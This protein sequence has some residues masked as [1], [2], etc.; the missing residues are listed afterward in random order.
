MKYS[1]KSYTISE[2]LLGKHW[3]KSLV[4][5]VIIFRLFPTKECGR[6]QH[7]KPLNKEEIV[8]I[9]NS[10]ALKNRLLRAYEMMLDFY[11]FTVVNDR[12]GEV[13]PNKLH[14]KRVS[15]LKTSRHNHLRIT[16]ILSSLNLLG[17]ECF[18]YPFLRELIHLTFGK[19][20]PLGSCQ[21]SCLHFWLPTVSKPT[22][23]HKFEKLVISLKKEI[24]D[25]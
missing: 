14:S 6:N 22:E 20:A 18:T 21:H 25:T 4:I 2:V 24:E 13:A 17:L 8:V 11:G 10:D 1:N 12:T 5:V 3:I 19:D 15:H 7:A 23:R 16:R 9:S